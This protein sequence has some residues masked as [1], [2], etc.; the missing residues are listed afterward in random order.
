MTADRAQ[1]ITVLGEPDRGPQMGARVAGEAR[2]CG[3]PEDGL[4][5]IQR[6][7]D[8]AMGNRDTLVPDDHHPMY[9]H[10]GRTILVSIRDGGLRDP[11]ALAASALLDT[12]MP[13]G[14]APRPQV[15]AD[16]GEVVCAFLESVPRP[17]SSRLVE[18]LVTAP[19]PVVRVALAEQLDQLR[20]ARLWADASTAQE[21]LD[22]SR[23]IY[24][25]VAER[26][27]GDFGR[28]FRWL[29]SRLERRSGT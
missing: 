9:L 16:V 22:E 28:R 10:P 17:D 3:V 14:E 27:G 13:G 26:L 15:A 29:C 20:H 23:R 12:R 1:V 2:R 4:A 25:P 24:L 21:V 5:L 11:V 7:H 19:D 8:L 6:A 18:E